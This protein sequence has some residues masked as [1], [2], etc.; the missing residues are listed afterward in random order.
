FVA[1]YGIAVPFIAA[2]VFG[3][4]IGEVNMPVIEW[5]LTSIP[6]GT[7]LRE[8]SVFGLGMPPLQYFIDAVPLALADYIIAFGDIL[9][10]D[11]LFKNAD[12]ARKDEKLVFSPRR[13]SIIVGVR[14]FLHGIF[15][16]FISLSGPAWTGGQVLVINRYMNN[17]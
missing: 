14:N 11:S 13:N 15:A 1:Q 6:M 4:L 10:L 16:P 17:P 2:Y 8:Y 7:I 5:G 3:I 12:V 9:V